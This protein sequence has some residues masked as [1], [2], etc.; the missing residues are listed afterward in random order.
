MADTS[1]LRHKKADSS[2]DDDDDSDDDRPK[3]KPVTNAGANARN[4][5]SALNSSGPKPAPFQPKPQ[6]TL[7]QKKAA[8]EESEAS[9]NAPHQAL[10]TPRRSL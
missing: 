5:I 8:A 7:L 2:D 6:A 4:I 1:W 3:A 9:R 10:A